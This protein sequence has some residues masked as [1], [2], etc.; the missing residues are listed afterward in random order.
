VIVEEPPYEL[1]AVFADADA[2]AFVERLVERGQERQCLRPFRWR[3]RR[4]AMR[5]GLVARPVDVV[6]ALLPAGL[7]PRVLLV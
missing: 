4:D 2:Q 7:Q 3:S 5:D 1:L 6:S